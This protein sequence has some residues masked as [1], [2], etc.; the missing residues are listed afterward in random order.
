MRHSLGTDT[1]YVTCRICGQALMIQERADDE[2]P[3][4]YVSKVLTTVEKYCSNTYH[5]ILAIMFALCT[6]HYYIKGYQLII[7]TDHMA[8][9]FLQTVKEPAG[10]LAR[11]M[12]ELQEYDCGIHYRKG[13]LQVLAGTLS[14]YNDT[15]EHEIT[16]FQQIKDQ[17]YFS[18]CKPDYFLNRNQQP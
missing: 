8:L 1:L 18:K 15:S 12:L 4:V 9:K 13:S 17:W 14:R 10:W 6:V 7:K 2:H 11:W 16:A 5:D 3:R